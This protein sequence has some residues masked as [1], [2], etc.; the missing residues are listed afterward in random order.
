MS[1]MFSA[2]IAFCKGRAQGCVALGQR[3]NNSFCSAGNSATLV[4]GAALQAPVSLAIWRAPRT[5]APFHRAALDRFPQR[6]A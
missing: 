4:G 1:H 2:D 5:T 6:L 3:S